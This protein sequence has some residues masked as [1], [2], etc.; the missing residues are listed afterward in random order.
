MISNIVSGKFLQVTS[1]NKNYYF[2]QPNQP[3][4]GMVRCDQYGKLQVYNGANWDNICSDS[5]IS[6]SPD[7]ESAITWAI[8]KMIEESKLK[9]LCDKNPSIRAA[10][11][12]KLKAEEKLKILTLLIDEPTL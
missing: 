3:L 12:E 7:A 1:N 2:A 6:L 9:E 8:D 11:E 4:I 10:Y 5:F